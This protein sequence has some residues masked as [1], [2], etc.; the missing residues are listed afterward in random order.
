MHTYL[1]KTE[2][3]HSQQVKKN[4][5]AHKWKEKKGSGSCEED[6]VTL[7]WEVL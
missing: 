5:Q 7:V 4:D 2:R 6:M 3:T 1:N